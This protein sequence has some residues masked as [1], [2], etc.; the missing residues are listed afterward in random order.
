MTNFIARRDHSVNRIAFDI[1]RD[2]QIFARLEDHSEAGF[3]FFPAHS[4]AE[5]IDHNA[6]WTG[7]C[8]PREYFAEIRRG[9]DALETFADSW[10]NG[11]ED[12][13]INEYDH[14]AQAD[15]N[16]HNELHPHGYC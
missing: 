7:L 8:S 9:Q 3:L 12:A 15:L 5:W 11:S 6:D 2:G 13:P 14:E 4:D 10:G 1:Y 16:L